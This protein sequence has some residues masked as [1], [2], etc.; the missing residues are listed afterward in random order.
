[1]ETAFN[2]TD[3]ENVCFFFVWFL[4]TVK[5][6]CIIMRIH[7]QTVA[8]MAIYWCTGSAAEAHSLHSFCCLGAVIFG[9]NYIC[10]QELEN[11][12]RRWRGCH[13]NTQ[14]CQIIFRYCCDNGISMPGLRG[15]FKETDKWNDGLKDHKANW[16]KFFFFEW[17]IE[18][19][20]EIRREDSLLHS[21]FVGVCIS[22]FVQPV[23]FTVSDISVRLMTA[24][25]ASR[26]ENLILSIH[27]HPLR[28]CVVPAVICFS[29][30]ILVAC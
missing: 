13:G 9:G 26:G 28:V 29:T 4:F 25:T 23:A 21:V 7:V 6:R 12:Y 27:K 15:W 10:R 11:C 3:P 1:M 22:C 5:I 20:A 14:S 2:M 18:L 30:N 19:E 8:P 24:T 17:C 16:L